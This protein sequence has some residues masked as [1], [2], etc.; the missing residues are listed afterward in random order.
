MKVDEQSRVQNLLGALSIGVSDRIQA[1]AAECVGH[2]GETAAALVQIG[3]TP[4]M[5]IEELSDALSLS[6]S[7]V[8][9]LVAK[10]T[11]MDFIERVAGE[12]KREVRLVLT[13]GGKATLK[14]IQ[15]A[16]SEILASLMDGL[17][18]KDVLTLGKMLESMLS[19]I[20][21]T[22][23]EA[24]HVCRYCQEDECPQDRCPTR[25]LEQVDAAE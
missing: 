6:H 22:Q 24:V 17:S 3:T 21:L 9:R 16:R 10:L 8:V 1:K 13:R 4:R 18:S 7:A 5:S 15:G 19:R 11:G 12:D 14:R 25:P 2:A 23:K 20:A